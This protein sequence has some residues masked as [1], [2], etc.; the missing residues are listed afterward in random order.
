MLLGAALTL[1]QAALA[2]NT[3]PNPLRNAYLGNLPTSA[4]DRAWTSPIWYTR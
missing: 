3:A 4:Q 1:T 2:E